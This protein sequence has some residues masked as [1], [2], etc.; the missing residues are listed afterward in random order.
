LHA[1]VV[2]KVVPG[3]LNDQTLTTYNWELT[4]VSK[5]VYKSLTKSN[6]YM[7]FFEAGK[8]CTYMYFQTFTQIEG[9]HCQTWRSCD[10]FILPWTGRFGLDSWAIRSKSNLQSNAKANQGCQMVCFQTKTPHLF[11]F[12]GPGIKQVGIFYIGPF[13]T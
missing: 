8:L 5:S 12:G 13:G 7:T 6:I 11:N 10:L 2:K 4:D 3:E 9:V 1:Y